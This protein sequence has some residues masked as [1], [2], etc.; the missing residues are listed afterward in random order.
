MKQER[1]Q[2]DEHSQEE[3]WTQRLRDHL[4]DIEAPVPD[5]LWAKIEV[6]L[7]KEAET[8]KR[9]ARTIPLWFK[10][11]AAASFI[12]IVTGIGILSWRQEKS[13]DS[14][15]LEVKAEK[16][17]PVMTIFGGEIPIYIYGKDRCDSDMIGIE[18]MFQQLIN[19]D[20]EFKESP[21]DQPSPTQLIQQSMAS[22]D[23]L[24]EDEASDEY[25][26]G[27]QPGENTMTK[28][29]ARRAIQDQQM[30][31]TE[32]SHASKIGLKLYA[33]NGFGYQS[34]QNGVLMSKE[35]LAHYDYYTNP[36]A[37]GTR[38]GGGVFLANH[39][40]KQNFYQPISL[41]LTV[42]I[43]ISSGFSIS[44]GVVYTRLSSDFTSI[45]N[46]L[47]YERQQRLHYV[48]IPLTIQY[49]VWQW[50]GLNVY[51]SAGG[52]ADFNVN[53]RLETEGVKTTI[54]KDN[55]QWSVNAALGVEYNVI[56]QIGIYAEPGIKH[57]FDNGSNLQNYFKYKPTNF[58]LQLGVRVNLGTD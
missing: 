3:Q 2:T 57:Y 10:W 43:P 54:E 44:T 8:T 36:Y 13:I 22:A 18:D 1:H 7:P 49:H 31:G 52:Q 53:A 34:H 50:R 5:D 9:P 21:D 47:V 12:G 39:E 26:A 14:Q 19:N 15:P 37:S 28:K 55:M 30:A 35:L 58:N 17:R 20:E 29:K 51:V 24:S 23:N 42:N 33:S 27:G 25:E 16:E 40:E 46:S 6:R 32:E 38:A 45:A 56:P 4:A 41:G 11:A 48:G